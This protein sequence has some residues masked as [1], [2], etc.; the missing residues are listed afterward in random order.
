M[1]FDFLSTGT[2]LVDVGLGSLGF[3]DFFTSVFRDGCRLEDRVPVIGI[4]NVN[5][6]VSIHNYWE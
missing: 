1:R 4:F 5:F 2:R 3:A 6:T